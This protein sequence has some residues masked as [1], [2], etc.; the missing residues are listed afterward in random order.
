M[1]EHCESS[2]FGGGDRAIG[3]GV[4]AAECWPDF[5]RDS[6]AVR[7]EGIG[8]LAKW[9]D[10]PPTTT[11]GHVASPL[12]AEVEQMTASSE[13][14]MGIVARALIERSA[15]DVRWFGVPMPADAAATVKRIDEEKG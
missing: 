6:A 12:A 11:Q 10:V 14:S 3:E 5:A 13:Q 7:F 4:A 1:T 15:E 8:A 2:D 9:L